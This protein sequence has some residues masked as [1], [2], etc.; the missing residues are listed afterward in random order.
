M[1]RLKTSMAWARSSNRPRKTPSQISRSIKRKKARNRGR[2]GRIQAGNA[3]LLTD[4]G[5]AGA[6]VPP[7]GVAHGQDHLRL[8]IEPEVL[9][10]EVAAGPI[11]GRLIAPEQCLPIDGLA[12]GSGVPQPDVFGFGEDLRHVVALGEA[13]LLQGDL[14]REGARASKTRHR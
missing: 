2:N 1:C 10:V 8:G 12:P 11:D 6:V 13:E 14:E 3:R 5:L 4:N 7:L 9:L